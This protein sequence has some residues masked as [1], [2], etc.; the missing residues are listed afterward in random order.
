MKLFTHKEHIKYLLKTLAGI[1]A[2]TVLIALAQFYLIYSDFE[3]SSK[4]FLFNVTESL[5]GRS[6]SLKEVREYNQDINQT[7]TY[8]LSYLY[9]AFAFDTL[10]ES[11]E[12]EKYSDFADIILDSEIEELYAAYADGTCVYSFYNEQIT[13]GTYFPSSEYGKS[14]GDLIKKGT[15]TAEQLE[16]MQNEALTNSI[17]SLTVERDGYSVDYQCIIISDDENKGYRLFIVGDDTTLNEALLAHLR[18]LDSYFD[19]IVNYDSIRAFAVDKKTGNIIYTSSNISDYAGTGISE[20]GLNT[21]LLSSNGEKTRVTLDG[22][23]TVVISR[24]FTSPEI[25]SFIFVAAPIGIDREMRISIAV[26]A[27]VMAVMVLCVFRKGIGLRG[28]GKK[29]MLKKMAV[30]S[31]AGVIIAAAASFYTR[32]MN[33]ISQAMQQG[34]RNEEVF[35]KNSK[36]NSDLAGAVE[37][38]YE[39]RQMSILNAVKI[40]FERNWDLVFESAD[41]NAV[42]TY[43]TKN[44]DGFRVTVKDSY[45]NPVRSFAKNYVMRN[46]ITAD[47]DIDIFLINNDGLTVA[48]NTGKWY[49]GLLS[50]FDFC[51]ELE[52]SSELNE[53]LERRS[54]YFYLREHVDGRNEVKKTIGIPID[55]YTSND[56]NG[57]TVYHASGEFVPGK[58]DIKKEYALLVLSYQDQD[59]LFVNDD[60]TSTSTLE[61]MRASENAMLCVFAE[62]EKHTVLNKTEDFKNRYVNDISFADEDFQGSNYRFTS[63]DG[64]GYFASLIKSEEAGAGSLLTLLEKRDVFYGRTEVTVVA[65]L[66]T[67][68][69][70][71]IMTLKMVSLEPEEETGSNYDRDNFT[72]AAR[73]LII[74]LAVFILI[75]DLIVRRSG[76][77]ST[78][79]SYALSRRWT[80]GVHIF[81]LSYVGYL[82]LIISVMVYAVKTLVKMIVPLLNSQMET[83]A[84]LF[85]SILEY[86]GILGIIFYSMYLFGVQTGTVITSAGIMTIVV[87]LGANSLIGDIVA[88]LFIII[89][90][91]YKVDDIVTIDNYTGVVKEIGLRTTKLLDSNGNVK[92]LNNSKINGVLNLT[93]NYSKTFITTS[94]SQEIP[95]AEAEKFIETDLK[96]YLSVNKKI[97]DGP[98]F[99]G[100]AEMKN[101]TYTV[102]IGI[103]CRQQDQWAVRKE[104]FRGLM[105]LSKDKGIRL[106]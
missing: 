13:D 29:A 62:D 25:G 35:K 105:Q 20:H 97:I 102:S 78:A 106:S 53:V 41:P 73:T 71:L 23:R 28:S 2:G 99:S 100:I 32:T 58:A 39:H 3:E 33:D 59:T 104:V 4:D 26:T 18:K 12:A 9:S 37:D 30:V 79:F 57:N 42:Y 16:W 54:P 5:N 101:G 6:E 82:L 40:C 38:Y 84:R 52:Y 48:T 69:I 56:G 96:N 46:M 91:E 90:R 43:Y 47:G 36:E 7:L 19:T 27:L 24:E 92:T 81:S 80:K 103:R 93:D 72:E 44:N 10:T 21:D 31:A 94:F 66:A 70:L 50:G 86:A 1:L 64:T 15:F 11:E 77:G 61:G 83:V 65:T 89:E 51:A 63:L 74:I 17:A 98:W 95:V 45:G 22:K 75:L 85:I 76:D 8:N 88:G 49:C 14:A 34:I 55:L 60:M 67:L 68:L 87:G